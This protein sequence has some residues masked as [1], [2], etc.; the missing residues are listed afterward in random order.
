MEK[1]VLII[2]A[3]ML[4]IMS[5]LALVRPI[6]II[7]WMHGFRSLGGKHVITYE[8][9]SMSELA[10]KDLQTY[11]RKYPTQ[12]GIDRGIGILSVLMLIATIC[13]V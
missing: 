12:V 8:Q 7:K 1:I 11:D 3:L 13:M 10:A 6:T 9:S 4:A 2:A 5:Y